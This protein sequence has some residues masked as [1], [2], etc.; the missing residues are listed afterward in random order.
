MTKRIRLVLD[1]DDTMFDTH[2][3]MRDILAQHGISHS[4]SDGYISTHNCP[5]E[6]LDTVLSEAKFMLEGRPLHGLGNFLQAICDSV[7]LYICTHRGYTPNGDEYT[8]QQFRTYGLDVFF[9]ES[10][11]L[12]LDPSEY[13]SKVEFLNE[14]FD[15]HPYVLVD[16]RPVFSAGDTP[17][18]PKPI[19]GC[20]VVFSRLWNIGK[21]PNFNHMYSWTEYS[22]IT[23]ALERLSKGAQHAASFP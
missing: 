2:R 7:D 13:S 10:R 16:D 18:V 8:A 4:A 20:V 17:N 3:A 14:Y 15:G 19:N 11:R 6:I 22:V 5:K 23:N 1:V 9:P 21:Y 12:F